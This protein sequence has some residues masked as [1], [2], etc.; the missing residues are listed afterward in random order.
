MIWMSGTDVALRKVDLPSPSSRLVNRTSGILTYRKRKEDIRGVMDVDWLLE[1]H[2]L[3]TFNG[4]RVVTL[5]IH[6]M[7]HIAS[8][9]ERKFIVGVLHPGNI[10]DHIRM[11]TNL[12]QRALTAGRARWPNR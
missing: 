7:F 5:H 8:P 6:E 12:R 4:D 11:D 2:V 3:T 1:F 10:S 9:I